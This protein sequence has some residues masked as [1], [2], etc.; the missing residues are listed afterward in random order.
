MRVVMEVFFTLCVRL[1]SFN[2]VE[3]AFGNIESKRSRWHGWMDGNL[4]SADRLGEVSALMDLDTVRGLLYEHY[5]QRKRKKTLRPLPGNLQVLILDG[6]E[7]CASYLRSCP[8]CSE[9]EV[10]YGKGREKRTQYYHRYVMAYLLCDGGRMLLDLELQQ[11]GE[12]EIAAAMRLLKRLLQ[13]CPRAFNVVAGDAL[14]LDPHLCTL[15]LNHKKDFI[16]VLKNENRGLIQDFRALL[17]AGKT[18]PVPFSY[19][20]RQCVCHDIKGFDS[21]TQLGRKVRVVRSFETWTVRRQRGKKEERDQTLTS[22]WLWAASLSAQKATTTAIV[23]IGHGRW[24]IENHAFNELAGLWHAD[25][26][27]HHDPNAIV[28]ILLLL[29]L[30]YNLFHAWLTRDIKPELRQGHTA[31]YFARLI[32]AEFY[33]QLRPPT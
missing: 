3:E 6:H 13:V 33:S 23:L 18:D 9:R 29:M 26:V 1:G 21:W 17:E 16:A 27:Y 31:L 15:I 10:T 2:G 14:Y 28:A 30:A 22:E 7:M 20:K 4:P 19:G 11:K 8:E 24:D 32:A 25:H 12:G 5:R